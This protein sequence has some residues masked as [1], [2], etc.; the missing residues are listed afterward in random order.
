MGRWVLESVCLKGIR[1]GI[2]TLQWRI[3]WTSLAPLLAKFLF[4]KQF[5]EN[6]WAN[7]RLPLLLGKPEIHHCTESIFSKV[8][9]EKNLDKYWQT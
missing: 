7:N 1:I 4:S 3:Q 6:N 8:R 2:I 9:S 5:L